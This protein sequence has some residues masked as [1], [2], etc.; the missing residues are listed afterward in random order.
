MPGVSGIGLVNGRGGML[1]KLLFS[2]GCE[3]SAA[4]A[5]SSGKGTKT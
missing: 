4:G 5:P 1:A 2:S 3:T